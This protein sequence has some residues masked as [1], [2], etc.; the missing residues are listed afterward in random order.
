MIQKIPLTRRPISS[1]AEYRAALRELGPYFDG[2]EIDPESARGQCFLAL[3]TLV[4]EYEKKHYP[5]ERE[6]PE[7]QEREPLKF[8]QEDR[9]W[10]DF[11]GPDPDSSR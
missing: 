6:Q 11:P 9:A 4:E 10:L 5:I 1:E 2:P 7:M 3:A 8:S